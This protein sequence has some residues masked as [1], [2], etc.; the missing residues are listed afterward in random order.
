MVEMVFP[1]DPSLDRRIICPIMELSPPFCLITVRMSS[2]RANLLFR[3]HTL[4]S[5]RGVPSSLFSLRDCK[6]IDAPFSLL[7][8]GFLSSRERLFNC[9]VWPMRPPVF[10]DPR[11]GSVPFFAPPS[12][13]REESFRSHPRPFPLTGGCFPSLT[14]S[15]PAAPSSSNPGRVF[16]PSH[17]DPVLRFP[18]RDLPMSLSSFLL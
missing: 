4:F 2:P 1:F 12:V 11:Q 17:I 16:P 5:R 14:C 8:F 10:F 18:P 9:S 13:E 6:A 3:P 15:P 7:G